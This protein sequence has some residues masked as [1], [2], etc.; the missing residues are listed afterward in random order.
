MQVKGVTT[1][2]VLAQA[3]LAVREMTKSLEGQHDAARSFMKSL[4]SSV[5]SLPASTFPYPTHSLQGL[6]FARRMPTQWRVTWRAGPCCGANPAMHN[7]CRSARV[8][9]RKIAHV[10]CPGRACFLK[11]AMRGCQRTR[12]GCPAQVLTPFQEAKLHVAAYPHFPDALLL[13]KM[14]AE[15]LGDA[16]ANAVLLDMGPPPPPAVAAMRAQA[17]LPDVLQATPAAAAAAAADGAGAPPAALLAVQE[18]G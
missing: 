17:A 13:S 1:V 18:A 7:T 12:L 8:C 6:L 3:T 5:C 15:E 9:N 16:S 2:P 4:L 11:S 14:I 10:C